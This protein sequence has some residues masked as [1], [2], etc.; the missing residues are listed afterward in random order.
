M[1]E[2]AQSALRTKPCA[3]ENAL[4]FLTHVFY[5][6]SKLA[7]RVRAKAFLL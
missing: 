4:L 7:V 2:F 1:L 5:R 6:V 3:V